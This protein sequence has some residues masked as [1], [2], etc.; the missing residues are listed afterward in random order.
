MPE[1][2]GQVKS[3]RK[4]MSALTD[5]DSNEMVCN[6]RFFLLTY[7]I[8]NLSF[9]SG[10]PPP[11]NGDAQPRLEL[12]VLS[13]PKES[14]MLDEAQAQLVPMESLYCEEYCCATKGVCRSCPEGPDGRWRRLCA[15][16]GSLPRL[17]TAARNTTSP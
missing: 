12:K 10:E 15:E 4:I 5:I 7:L 1:F 9:V 11:L 3:F 14:S 13:S 8:V 2:G 16:N 17:N 6:F